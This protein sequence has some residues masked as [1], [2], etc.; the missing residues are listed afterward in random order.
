MDHTREV[1][2]SLRV[3]RRDLQLP[4]VKI[5]DLDSG[6]PLETHNARRVRAD[7]TGCSERAPSAVRAR[8][9]A[10]PD[11]VGGDGGPVR[12]RRD[13]ERVLR[14]LRA[15]GRGRK[16]GGDVRRLLCGFVERAAALF[17]GHDL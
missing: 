16:R 11:G 9:R 17:D 8:R 3:R 4:V 13:R 10:E 1:F 12:T 15:E 5:V 7:R 14:R 2:C 6:N